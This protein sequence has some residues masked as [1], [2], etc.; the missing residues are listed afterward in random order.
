VAIKLDCWPT[1][2]LLDQRSPA[3]VHSAKPAASASR[4]GLEER[5][6]DGLTARRPPDF[7]LRSIRGTGYGRRAEQRSVLAFRGARLSDPVELRLLLIAEVAVEVVERAA[8]V[9]HRP[10][11]DLEPF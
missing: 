9:L 1:S 2:A 7:A 8:H 10:A 6:P 3:A 5:S 11:H 4:R